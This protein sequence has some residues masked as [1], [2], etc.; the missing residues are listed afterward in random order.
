MGN[1]HVGRAMA[2]AAEVFWIAKKDSIVEPEHALEALDAAARD[3]H[4]ADAE[5]DD[6]FRSATPLARLVAVA[7]NA[8]PA[9]IADRDSGIGDRWYDGPYSRFQERYKFC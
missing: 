2:A 1:H 4:G 5:F 3:F 8:S 9:E 7:F 6:E